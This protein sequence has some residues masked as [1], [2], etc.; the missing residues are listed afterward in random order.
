MI[1]TYVHFND[2]TFIFEPTDYTRLLMQN[3]FSYSGNSPFQFQHENREN[4]I[5]C[6][7]TR[8][9]SETS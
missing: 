8:K 3:V 6:G 7:V 5:D 4:D 1:K 2:A 9:Y